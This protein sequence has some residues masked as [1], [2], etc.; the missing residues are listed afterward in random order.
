MRIWSIHPKY[1]DAKGLVAVWRETLLAKHVLA[2]KTKGYKHHPQLIRFK[3]SG[4]PIGHINRYLAAIHAEAVVRGY[5]FD[6]KKIG[7]RIS[8][9]RLTVTRGQ[10]E[11]ERMHLMRK[12]KERDP[13]RYGQFLK[14]KKFDPH[15]LF[16]VVNGGVAEWEIARSVS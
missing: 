15:P 5:N 10:M 4:D 16:K 6:R 12:L 1:L 14:E 7:R 11:Y 8:A 9:R 2:G 3:G 13:K